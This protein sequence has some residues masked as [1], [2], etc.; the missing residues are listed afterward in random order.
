MMTT[1][2]IRVLHIEDNPVEA[3]LLDVL[4]KNGGPVQLAHAGRLDE[5]L[6]KTQ[7]ADF[8]AVLLDLSLPDAQGWDVLNR[9]Q[10]AAPHAPIIILTSLDDE[11][12]SRECAR[13]G[14]QDYL[15]KGEINS[16]SLRRTL[17][18]AI[19]R[20]QMRD[21]LE[22]LVYERTSELERLNEKLLQAQK[23]EVMG[24]LTGGI[25]HDFNNLLSMMSGYATFLK[26]SLD[27]TDPRRADAEE[28]RNT[29]DR[30]ASLTRQLLNFSR[31]RPIQQESLD[32]NS[33]IAS[34]EKMI[35]RLL[36]ERITLAIKLDPTPGW[37]YADAGQIEQ[38]MLNL[39]VNACD[40]M[41]DGGALTISTE[42]VHE[43][44]KR[45]MVLSVEDTGCGMSA[46]TQ[47]HLFE[48]F[49]TT[50][51][52]GTGLGLT[53]IFGIVKR[54]EGT[55]HVTSALGRGTTFKVY[56]PYGQEPQ[57]VNI[58]KEQ[59]ATLLA[60]KETIL[61]VEDEPVIRTLARR[62]L[63]GYGYT[64]LD[65]SDG[66]EAL[67]LLQGYHGSIDLVV[68]DVVMPS[69][70]G[71]DLADRVA[72]LHPAIKVLYWS[73]YSDYTQAADRQ[74]ESPVFFL[75]KPFSPLQ[76]AQKVRETLDSLS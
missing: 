41:A 60:G 17:L 32:L 54:L 58:K 46:E 22:K 59:S 72:V 15:L 27:T 47:T 57:S 44:D 39:V 7:A 29:V 49:F 3:R 2:T 56:F 43:N 61:I 64:L 37:I 1:D 53:T 6:K 20:R 76:L 8:D 69:M 16:A 25:A 23:M 75:P 13:F 10:A 14:V 11:H 73:G 5:A 28:I 45:Y 26:D 66:M 42:I 4:L 38:V 12:F 55:I 65:A 36:G 74:Q 62:T 9:V 35:R 70:G 31:M 40:A 30:A 51:A 50:R 71:L 24:R 21:R 68:T 34:M 63:E 52:N 19:E 18:Y 67:K 33:V 48:P